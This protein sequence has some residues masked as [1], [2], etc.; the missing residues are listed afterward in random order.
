M[1]DAYED[2]YSV[3]CSVGVPGTLEAWPIGKA[4]SLPWFVYLL[5]EDGGLDADD[6]NYADVPRFRI[7]LYEETRDSELEGSMEEAIREAF[8][9]VS[10]IA[11]WIPDENARMVAYGF[12]YTP[13][14]R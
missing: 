2:V 4:P 14:E 9:P 13:K 11:E 3:A 1:S 10:V 8:G 12:A 7:E 5:D 6:D